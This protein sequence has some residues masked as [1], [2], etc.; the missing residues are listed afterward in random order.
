MCLYIS[1]LGPMTGLP[2]FNFP[3]FREA[4]K[5]LRALGWEVEDPSEHFGGS[6]DLPRYKYLAADV[7]SLVTKCDAIAFL[8]GWWESEGAKLEA[9]IALDR[10][11]DLYDWDEGH[12]DPLTREQVEKPMAF[13]SSVVDDPWAAERQDVLDR[14]TQELAK[15]TGD[16]SKK[17]QSGQKP[18]WYVDGAHEAAIFS[19][20]AK[21]KRGE[22]IDPD[23][24][25]HTLVNCAWRCLA[26]AC[27]ET[28]NIPEEGT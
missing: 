18:P 2:D 7:V 13:F 25:A 28:G 16:G 5:A 9:Q 8:P 3:A 4:A 15:A 24:G 20:L 22:T 10:G 19:H 14:F 21:W 12:L 27:K 11:Y 23:S 6:T 17:R 26:I 1:G